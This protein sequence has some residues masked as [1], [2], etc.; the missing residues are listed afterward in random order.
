MRLAWEPPGRIQ[1]YTSS[2]DASRPSITLALNDFDPGE[3]LSVFI[4][5]TSGDLKPIL[6]LRDYGGKPVRVGNLQGKDN[7]T[8]LEYAFPEG[9]QAYTLEIYSTPPGGSPPAGSSACWRAW[10]PRS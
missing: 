9:G 8:S 2:L 4:E 5:A 6:V 10:M 3:T 7:Q 1:E